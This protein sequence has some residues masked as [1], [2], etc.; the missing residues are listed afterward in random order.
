MRRKQ[1]P[2]SIRLCLFIHCC[3]TPNVLYTSVRVSRRP[4]VQSEPKP[5]PTR[6]CLR[7]KS[8]G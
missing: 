1:S 7:V 2:V 4:G 5:V 8:R 3:W 6:L